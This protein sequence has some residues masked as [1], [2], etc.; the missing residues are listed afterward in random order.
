V[1]RLILVKSVLEAIS[2]YWMSL[3]WIP[4]GILGKVRHTCFRF[5][6]VG[7]K[8]HFVLPWVKWELLAAPK[9]LGW[10][11]LKYIYLFAKALATKASWRLIT[12]YSL[13]TKV[14]TRKYISPD[15]VEE[16]IRRPSKETSNCLIIW[17]ALIN[18]FQVVG[19]GLAWHVGKGTR[20][21]L[22]TDS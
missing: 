1:G 10:W 13:S 4:K 15:S 20:V 2:V 16:W 8:D 19:E 12:T 18:Y 3:A 9:L 22:G 11:R 14:V 7:T 6:W 21:E 5:L 17:K